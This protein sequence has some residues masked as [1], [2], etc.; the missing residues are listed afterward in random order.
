MRGLASCLFEVINAASNRAALGAVQQGGFLGNCA[1][2]VRF[3]R[4]EIERAPSERLAG[5][6]DLIKAFAFAFTQPDAFLGSEVG[7]HDFQQ[8]ESATANFGNEPLADDP[9]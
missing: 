5:L 7:P 3:E 4:G 6:D 1:L 9:A 8:S 2:F